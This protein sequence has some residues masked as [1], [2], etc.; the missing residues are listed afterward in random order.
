MTLETIRHKPHLLISILILYYSV[1]ILLFMIGET[2]SLFNA[3][4]PF[5][6]ILSFGAVLVYQKELTRKLG[7][8]FIAV[9]TGT[10]IIEIIGVN[11]GVLFGSYVYGN[12]LGIKIFNTPV[13]IGL[14]W[15][16]LIYCTTAIVNHLFKEKVTRIILGSVMMVGYDLLLEY[17]AP[18]MAMWSWDT[19]YPGIRNFMMWFIISMVL[20]ILFQAIDHRIEN[21][22]ARYLF[23]IQILFF[24]VIAL[25]HLWISE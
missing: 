3:L 1:G 25:S 16:I 24:S 8:V 11:T 4:T 19:I 13:L 20:H 7:I 18:V 14:N 2:R 6:L 10:F 21:K 23:L 12:A 5:S 9:F 17:V 15:L 22:P